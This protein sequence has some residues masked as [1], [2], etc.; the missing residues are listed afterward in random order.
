V[1][2]YLIEIG[3]YDTGAAALTTLRFS[4]QPYLHPSAPG[5]FANRVKDLPTFRRD[6]FSKNT[7]GGAGAVSLGDMTLANPD[8]ALDNLRGFG[9]AGQTCTIKLGDDQA[10]YSSFS[11]FIV[12]RVDQALFDLAEVRFKLK[13]RMQDL[14]QPV[15]ATKYAGTNVLPDGLEG[16]D[17]L[18]GKP[19]PITVGSA[20]NLSAVSVNSARLEYQVN[21]G[22]VF[23]VTIVRDAGAPLTREADY[24]NQA[25]MDANAPSAGCYRVWKAGGYF[26]LG[27]SPFGVITADVQ[28]ANTAGNTAAQ[29]AQTIVTRPGGIAIGDV[30]PGDVTVLDAA[31][32]ATVGIWINAETNFA[33]VLDQVLGSVGGWYGFDRIGQFRMQRVESPTTPVATLRRF[34]LGTDAGLTDLDMVDCRFLSTNDPD[35]GV[36]SWQ[37]SLTYALNYTVMTGNGVAGVVDDAA[38]AYLAAA[39]R[40]AISTDATVKVANPLAVQKTVATLLV[41][42]ADAQAEADRILGLYKVRRDFIEVD[43]PLTPDALNLLDLGRTVSVII[44]RFG[45]DTGR[46]MVITGMEY[47]SVRNILIVALWG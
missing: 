40:T 5:P 16:L 41:N 3:A 43:T 28:Q 12:G 36:P 20:L 33:A 22:L 4:S 34:G 8:G 42:Q 1:Q 45:Y 38:R 18:Y 7:T 15:Q 14:Q 35:K 31:N 47:N 29:V 24:A 39:T 21:D 27:S 32:S 6:I 9:L 44:P 11:T 37:V 2:T 46:L 26:R 17:D 19:K 10:P 25:D 30:N 13:D 23:D